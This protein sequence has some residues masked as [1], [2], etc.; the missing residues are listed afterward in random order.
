MA[1]PNPN[2]N[3]FIGTFG[4]TTFRFNFIGE[5]DKSVG[6]GPY[7]RCK[8]PVLEIRPSLLKNDESIDDKSGDGVSIGIT[9][10]D[11][12]S[13]SGTAS[14]SGSFGGF[15]GFGIL[16]TS[17]I[18]AILDGLDRSEGTESD[19]KSERAFLG[20]IGFIGF[21]PLNGGGALDRDLDGFTFIPDTDWMAFLEFLEMPCSIRCG[22]TGFTTLCTLERTDSLNFRF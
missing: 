4:G 15:G 17:G 5:P 13:S 7:S 11:F 8:E 22:F 10:C 18:T 20:L 6:G 3:R 12:S 16:G 21:T 14:C 9:V 2:G 1:A 19:D